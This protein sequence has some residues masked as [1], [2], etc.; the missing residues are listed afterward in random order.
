MK[1]FCSGHENRGQYSH[2]QRLIDL[3]KKCILIKDQNNKDSF[4]TN[5]LFLAAGV[6]RR[7]LGTALVILRKLNLWFLLSMF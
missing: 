4:F 3:K 6:E 2:P 1:N 7:D 5:P